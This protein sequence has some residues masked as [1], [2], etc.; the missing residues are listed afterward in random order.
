MIISTKYEG[1]IIIYRVV[2]ARGWMVLRRGYK[3][4]KV[5]GGGARKMYSF[6]NI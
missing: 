3:I 2:G 5:G 1:V 4:L 6:Y